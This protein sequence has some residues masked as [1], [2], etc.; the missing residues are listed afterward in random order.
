MKFAK[1]LRRKKFTKRVHQKSSPK[2][3]TKEVHQKS[4]PKSSP[5]KYLRPKKER[6][7]IPNPPPSQAGEEPAVSQLYFRSQIVTF[8]A[9]LLSPPETDVCGEVKTSK[10]N[11]R[12]SSRVDINSALN[13][14]CA[15]T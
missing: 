10:W 13:L 14:I 7:V 15:P 2:K 1:R 9:S 11:N 3:F 4:S 5:K 12:H 8:A 6:D